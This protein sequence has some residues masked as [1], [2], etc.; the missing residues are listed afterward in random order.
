MLVRLLR[1]QEAEVR[2]H[3]V[4]QLP[5]VGVDMPAADRQTILLT[6]FITHVSDIASDASEGWVWAGMGLRVACVFGTAGACMHAV[7][8]FALACL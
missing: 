1:D 7:L 3:A 6:N 2:T 4:F 5:N 8:N